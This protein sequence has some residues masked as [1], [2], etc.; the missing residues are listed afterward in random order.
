[1][2]FRVKSKQCA[3]CIFGSRTPITPERFEELKRTWEEKGIVQQCHAATINNEDTACRG[4]YEAA[5][6]EEIP[7]PAL[8][9]AKDLLGID[10]EAVGVESVFTVLERLG[11]ITF[12]D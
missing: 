6:R 3:T 12:E 10:H 7:H 11:L 9:L 4:H 8:G 1:M 5:R 2:S